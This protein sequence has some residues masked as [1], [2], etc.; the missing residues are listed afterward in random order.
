MFEFLQAYADAITAVATVASVV[1]V[2]VVLWQTR[3][4]Q[5]RL[6]SSSR[7]LQAEMLQFNDR[8][9][10]AAI[11]AAAAAE[12]ARTN[13]ENRRQST[14]LQFELQGLWLGLDLTKCRHRAYRLLSEA[15]KAGEEDIY[16]RLERQQSEDWAYIMVIAHFVDRVVGH[17]HDVVGH[18]HDKELT[19]AQ[20]HRALPAM[21]WWAERLAEPYRYIDREDRL[22]ANL[23]TYAEKTTRNRHQIDAMTGRKK[24]G[25]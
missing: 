24:S 3:R 8:N 13:A 25:T 20:A 11:E 22:T 12:K 15:K 21:R 5:D 16:H 17:V 1:M 19:Y 9:Q 4:N 6:I 2:L 10:K 18:V 14:A 7:E 23:I